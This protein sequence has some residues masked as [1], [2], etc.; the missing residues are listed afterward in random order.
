MIY[1][2]QSFNFILSILINRKCSTI[3]ILGK[4]LRHVASNIVFQ[5]FLA[6]TFCKLLRTVF[7]RTQ[8]IFQ[9]FS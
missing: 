8:I 1:L 7:L 9:G 5:Y 6:V 3:V 2:N 4:I